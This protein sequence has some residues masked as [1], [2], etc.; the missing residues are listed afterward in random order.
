MQCVYHLQPMADVNTPAA[1]L[2]KQ[3]LVMPIAW[4]M[5]TYMAL[6][7]DSEHG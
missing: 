2:L 5:P 1:A 4:H 7:A 6:V 3:L